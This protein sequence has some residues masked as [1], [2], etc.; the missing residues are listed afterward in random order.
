MKIS[1]PYNLEVHCVAENGILIQNE[2]PVFFVF[3]KCKSVV[4]TVLSLL[5]ITKGFD[6]PGVAIY[7]QS[8]LR[9]M[10]IHEMRCLNLHGNM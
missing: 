1:V 6:I 7:L 8:R 2:V 9:H 5:W 4:I 10:L 3:L